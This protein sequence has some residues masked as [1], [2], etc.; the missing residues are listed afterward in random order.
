MR[1]AAARLGALLQRLREAA[2]GTLRGAGEGIPSATGKPRVFFVVHNRNHMSIF[3]GFAGLLRQR[4]LE[5]LF[6]TIGG[7]RHEGQAHEAVR[8]YGEAPFDIAH[9]MKHATAADII[10]VGNDWGPRRLAGMLDRLRQRGV[11]Q[12]AVVEGARFNQ[13]RHYKRVDELLCWGPSG[14]EIGARKARIVGSP[15]IEKAAGLPRATAGS[16]RVL[17]NYKFSGT[18]EDSDFSWGAAAIAAAREIDPAFILSTHPSSRAVPPDVRV[19][20]EPFHQLL[21]RSTIVITKASTVIYESLAAGVAVLYFPAPG[22]VQAEF[23]DARGAFEVAQTPESL[24]QAARRYAA[25][26]DFPGE[27]AAAF[28]ARHV[29]VEPGHPA[30]ARIAEAILERVQVTGNEIT[31]EG[32]SHPAREGRAV[33]ELSA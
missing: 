7:H 17:V 12:V 16:P 8:A 3:T 24:L 14:L 20:H 11:P 32:K 15:V 31:H 10:V 28:L 33:R 26:P 9:M 23:A 19:S 4:G 29:A 1:R 13:P 18:D 27:A 30:N 21:S 6:C 22:E 2:V 25:A 5:T